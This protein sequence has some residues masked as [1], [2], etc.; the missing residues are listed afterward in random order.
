[1]F[2]TS[3]DKAHIKRTIRPLYAFTQSTPKSVFL[4]PSFDRSVDVWPGMCFQRAGGD[5]VNLLDG[6]GIP[7]GLAAEFIGGDGVDELENTGVNATAV[8]VLGP[9]AEFEILAPAFDDSLTW[10]DPTDGTTT[11]VHASTTGANQGKLVPAGALNASTR[12]I[13]RLLKVESDSKIIIGG[14]AANLA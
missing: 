7:Y 13:A 11:L 4:D 1:M 9:D 5:L 10:T 3:L 14:L 12:P 2:Y 6:T 8:W